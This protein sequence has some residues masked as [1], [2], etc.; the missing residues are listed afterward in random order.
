M[1][2]NSNRRRS[3]RPRAETSH[4]THQEPGVEDR[5]HRVQR[6]HPPPTG[7]VVR[8]GHAHR[9]GRAGDDLH[10][11]SRIKRWVS[12]QHQRCQPAH[13]RRSHR[14]TRTFTVGSTGECGQQVDAGGNDLRFD[15]SKGTRPPTRG[16]HYLVIP[17]AGADGQRFR[18]AGRRADGLR[19]GT[20]IAGGKDRQDTSSQQ[21]LHVGLKFRPGANGVGPGVVEDIGCQGRVAGRCQN[22]L[23]ASVNPTIQPVSAAVKGANSDPARAGCNAQPIPSHQQPGDVGAVP[24]AV[25]RVECPFAGGIVPI[26]AMNR[27]PPVPA[28]VGRLQ[29]GVHPVHAGIHG[30][31]HYPSAVDLQRRPDLI[32]PDTSQPPIHLRGTRLAGRRKIARIDPPPP[33]VRSNGEHIVAGSQP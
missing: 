11:P 23:K 27:Y 13:Q 5:Y 28:P 9:D 2:F 8:P 14:G 25:H 16:R 17:V 19:Q 32:G 30:R 15:T 12:L 31:H 24:L 26:T 1:F 18:Q 33:A 3:Q 10:H 29:G 21:C 22:P 20:E 6:I 4:L 7:V